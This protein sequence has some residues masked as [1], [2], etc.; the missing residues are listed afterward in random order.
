MSSSGD[1]TYNQSRLQSHT[2]ASAPRLAYIICIICVLLD[3]WSNEGCGNILLNN[4]TQGKKIIPENKNQ[5]RISADWLQ[6]G[7]SILFFLSFAVLPE[8]SENGKRKWP[9][10]NGM[11]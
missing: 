11:S 9:N 4:A 2:C 10:G 1:R 5:I 7:F 3:Y 8:F 6:T